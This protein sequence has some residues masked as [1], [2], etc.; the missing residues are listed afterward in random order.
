M[1]RKCESCSEVTEHT[2]EDYE[3]KGFEGYKVVTCNDCQSQEMIPERVL[4]KSDDK[5]HTKEN[6]VA[7][8]G[9]FDASSD[10]IID[11][12]CQSGLCP[13]R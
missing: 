8:D 2:V 4:N 1:Q 10:R 13:S 5:I 12:G 11:D 3:G 6:S 9:G 7:V